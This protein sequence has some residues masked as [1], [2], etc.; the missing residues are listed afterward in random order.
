MILITVF[1]LS[2]CSKETGFLKPK[3]TSVNGE[4]NQFLQIVD[5]NYKIVESNE[6]GQTAEILVELKVIK[7]LQNSSGKFKLIVFDKDNVPIPNASEFVGWSNQ[8]LI[9]ALNA[10]SGNVRLKFTYSGGGNNY[11]NLEKDFVLGKS[12]EISSTKEN[13]APP[14]SNNLNSSSLDLQ[15]TYNGNISDFPIV[16]SINFFD[17][18]TRKVEGVY[19][20]TKHNNPINI[21]GSIDN[22]NILNL[23]ET[24]NGKVTGVFKGKFEYNT[25]SGNWTTPDG[26]KNLPFSV[27][28]PD[29]PSSDVTDS[30]TPDNNEMSSSS[31]CD[32]FIKNYEAFADSY[33]KIMRKFKNNPSDP[34]VITEYTELVQKAAEMQTNASNCSDSKYTTKLLQIANKM[35]KAMQ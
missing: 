2:S 18:N 30:F 11:K 31:N 21:T 29:S 34:D 10:G 26:K 20:Y 19:Y 3:S 25:I 17:A 23:N 5:Q 35:A 4:L 16:L 1:L 28:K 15:G 7:Q 24:S 22:N 14:S 12:F 13:V 27:S 33:V 8:E 6:S 32:E 9:S